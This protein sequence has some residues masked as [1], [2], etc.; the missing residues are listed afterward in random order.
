MYIYRHTYIHTYI[1]IH[2]Y[3]GLIQN[4]SIDNNGEEKLEVF[5]TCGRHLQSTWYR[6]FPIVYLCFT[7]SLGDRRIILS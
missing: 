3:Q 4:L 1:Y 6:F 7:R 2:I 5:S